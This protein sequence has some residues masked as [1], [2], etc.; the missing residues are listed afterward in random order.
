LNYL[1]IPVLRH[2]FG[3]TVVDGFKQGTIV[4]TE[5][6]YWTA[7]LTYANA[8]A[9]Y[10]TPADIGTSVLVEVKD[11]A[12][13]SPWNSGAYSTLFSGTVLFPDFSF[14]SASIDVGFQG[15]GKGYALNMMNCA[16][17][18]GTQS[19]YPALDTLKEILTDAS[20][21]IIT[22]WVN[23]YKGTSTASGYSI[24]TS[25]VDVGSAINEVIPFISF[26]W[27]PADS[28][29]NDL[30][31]LDTAL[32]A[33]NIG[34]HWIVDHSGNLRLKQ[35]GTSQTG[36]TKYYGNSSANATL[37]AGEDFFDGDF[38][39]ISKEANIVLYYGAWRRPDNGDF[40]EGNASSFGTTGGTLTYSDDST[41]HCVG[42]YG[43]RCNNSILG[44][45]T[46]QYPVTQNAAWDF[47]SFKDFNTPS[48]NFSLLISRL[49]DTN[50]GAL[51]NFYIKLVTAGGGGGNFA[52][53]PGNTNIDKT[54]EFRHFD[55]PI[56][57]NAGQTSFQYITTGSPLWSKID[58]IEIYVPFNDAGYATLDGLHFG[59]APICRIARQT[60][61]TEGMPIGTLGTTSN[62][63]RFKVLTDNIGKDDSLVALDDSG[64]LAQ[65]AKAEL[66][67][68]SKTVINGKFTTP[69]IPD[70]FPG[71]YFYIGSKDW[72]ITK[73]THNLAAMTSAFEVTDDLT[74]SHQRLRYEDK[75]KQFAAMRPEYQDKQAT[76]IK[77]GAMDIRVLPLEKAYNI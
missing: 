35:I 52:V 60:L 66:I 28:C 49:M 63:M 16:E 36:W 70:V 33:S 4:L 3:S 8:P 43:V 9:I 24:D 46:F 2:T 32:N 12:T 47:S 13:D 6:A 56:G 1:K 10:P 73:I 68:L 76:S 26:P 30:C 65:M 5:N 34:P 15:V 40:S 23:K 7:G 72:R 11:N 14:N 75:N 55:Y 37:I 51:N 41:Y 62:P 50:G 53:Y 22:K 31:D 42:N 21:G 45:V 67:R 61:P 29:L 57:P 27:K 74:N 64:L 17:E 71:Q 20:Y 19:K 59:T 44:G 38:Q 48:L 77:S 69:L 54:L 25:N 39:P 58:Y 18:Y